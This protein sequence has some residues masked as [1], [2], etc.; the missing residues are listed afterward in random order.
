[1]EPARVDTPEAVPLDPVDTITRTM[2]LG[3]LEHVKELIEKHRYE[4][5]LIDRWGDDI[6][7]VYDKV[8]VFKILQ[9]S[10]SCR[11]TFSGFCMRLKENR[12]ENVCLEFAGRS[13][14]GEPVLKLYG[15]GFHAYMS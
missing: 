11:E 6:F 4:V 9:I 8:T 7:A 12:L 15:G 10:R 1:M 2:L 14:E 5:V 3:L 13:E